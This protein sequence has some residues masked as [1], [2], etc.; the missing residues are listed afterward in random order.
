VRK[1]AAAEL[2]RCSLTS[3]HLKPDAIAV[4]GVVGV[5]AALTWIFQGRKNFHGPRDLGGLLELARAEVD[6][7][8]PRDVEHAEKH[9]KIEA[10]N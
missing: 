4:F 7:P 3:C 6:S 9:G 8:A 2:R 5:I 10:V 1:I